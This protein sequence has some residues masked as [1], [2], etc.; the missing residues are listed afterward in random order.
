[1]SDRVIRQFTVRC[2]T[3]ERRL[4][5][6]PLALLVLG[7]QRDP[8][9][10]LMPQAL[11]PQGLSPLRQQHG[12]RVNMFKEPRQVRVVRCTGPEPLGQQ[13]PRKPDSIRSYDD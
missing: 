10:L 11:L 12:P 5:A 2:L 7:L 1:M 6:Q 8:R 4:Q 3:L 13:G 9:L